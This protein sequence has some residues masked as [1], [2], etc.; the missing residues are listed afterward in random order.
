MKIEI[1]WSKILLIILNLYY[2][3]I[4]NT[5]V[6]KKILNFNINIIYLLFLKKI[7]SIALNL[8]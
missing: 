5:S 6:I 4:K 7:L 3:N 8:I 1:N 2:D